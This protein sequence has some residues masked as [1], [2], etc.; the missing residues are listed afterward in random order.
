MAPYTKFDHNSHFKLVLLRAL[1]HVLNKFGVLR[2]EVEHA[3]ALHYAFTALLLQLIP[4]LLRAQH[5]RHV[6]RTFT[7]SV[8]N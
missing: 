6:A 8:T 3:A 5:H 1:H 2:R 7:V 4:Q